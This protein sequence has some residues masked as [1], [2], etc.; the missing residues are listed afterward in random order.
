MDKENI[1]AFFEYCTKLFEILLKFVIKI[2]ENI[3][4]DV[5][6][7]EQLLKFSKF[8]D[9]EKINILLKE[10]SECNYKISRNANIKLLFLNLAI[11]I[12]KIIKSN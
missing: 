11:E 2:D 12:N 5:E 10:F 7:Q 1:K 3:G 8:L 4:L 6:K 9:L